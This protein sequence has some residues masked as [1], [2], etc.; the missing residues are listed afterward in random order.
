M[1]AQL[2]TRLRDLNTTDAGKLI[3]SS[4]CGGSATW[5]PPP[6]TAHGGSKQPAPCDHLTGAVPPLAILLLIHV[7]CIIEEA[8]I[9]LLGDVEGAPAAVLAS[10]LETTDWLWREYFGEVG[11]YV[12]MSHSWYLER[13]SSAPSSRAASLSLLG[14]PFLSSRRP[15]Y[16]PW[17]T[18]SPSSSPSPTA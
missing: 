14:P 10:V 16:T 6:P 4:T 8:S 12:L 18:A 13:V 15:S 3:L 5:H 1:Q 11:P 9:D 7:S 17:R 2:E